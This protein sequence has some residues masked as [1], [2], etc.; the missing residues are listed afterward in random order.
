V[1]GEVDETA[2]GMGVMGSGD[3]AGT[4]SVKVLYI[5]GWGRSG[6]TILDNVLGQVQGFFTAGELH[7]LWDHLERKRP[8]GCRRPISQCPVWSKVSRAVLNA[9]QNPGLEPREI[10]RWQHQEMRL[11]HTLRLMVTGKGALAGPA[12]LCSY[13]SVASSLYEEIARETGARVVIDSTKRPTDA[14]LLRLLPSVDLYLVHLVR[15]PRAVA[16]SWQ[17]HRQQIDRPTEMDRYGALASSINWLAWNLAAEGICRQNGR[18]KS[19][20]LRYEDFVSRPADSVKQVI[21][22]VGEESADLSFLSSGTVHLDANHSVAGNPRRFSTGRVVLHTDDDW[23]SKQGGWSR[24]VATTVTLPLLHRY[25][26]P[27]VVNRSQDATN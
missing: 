3:S 17:R 8:C 6:S 1:G 12:P 5:L 16:Y 23:R 24:V 21:A 26:Y 15:D 13:S 14:A 27:W 9:R 10:V 2:L 11:R 22:L 7:Y 20:L 18:R 19:L 4:T 25:R